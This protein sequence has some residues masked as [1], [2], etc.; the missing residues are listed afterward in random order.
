VHA[1][2]YSHQRYDIVPGQLQTVRQPDIVIVEG[3]NV[4]QAPP[5][6]RDT[7]QLFASDFFDFSIY[8]DADQDVIEEW[9]IARFL[10]L[11]E[12]VFQDP[13]SYF[14]RYASLNETDAR[15]TAA[16]IWAEINA[17]NLRENIQPTRMRAHLILTKGPRHVVEHVQLRRV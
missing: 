2:V 11:V 17:P 13:D 6:Q 3:L 12:T 5:H 9:Y 15:A 1:P 4:L 7:E 14:H 8:V 10:R 16:R